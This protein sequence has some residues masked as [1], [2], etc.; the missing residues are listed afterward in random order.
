MFISCSVFSSS[1]AGSWFKLSII[2]EILVYSAAICCF[3]RSI[4]LDSSK[5]T[6]NL[7]GSLLTSRPV[8]E[9]PSGLRIKLAKPLNRE[10][11]RERKR[12]REEQRERERERERERGTNKH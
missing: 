3:V 1:S 8:E 2:P 4:L 6:M 5:I 12:E 10:R 11:E 9:I 7:T